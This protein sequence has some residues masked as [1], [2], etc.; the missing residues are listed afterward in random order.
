MAK[1]PTR[2]ARIGICLSPGVWASSATL[3]VDLTRIAGIIARARP[4]V[5]GVEPV[6]LGPRPGPV[7]TAGG[8]VLRAEAAWAH[9]DVDVVVV[10]SVALPFLESAG[11][12]PG[13]AEW[14]ARQHRRGSLLLAITTGSWLLAGTG[15]LDGHI[16]TTHWAALE[17]CRRLSPRVRWTSSQPLAVTGRL[18][19]ARDMSAA[20]TALCHLLG[21][22]VN[23]A[24]AERTYQYALVSASGDDALPL[25][26]TVPLREHGDAQVL[27]AQDWLEQHSSEALTMERLARTVHMSARN[28]RRRFVTA[29]GRSLVEY[30][31]E[32]RLAR[33]RARLLSTTEPVS[34]IAY[35]VGYGDASTFTALFK[36]RHGLT[37]SAFREAAAGSVA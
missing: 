31:T 7:K 5:R 15:V 21:R 6:L 16:A 14:L 27:A 19:T 24:V 36:Q 23:A 13:L 20:S 26:H 2:T 34:Q 1:R 3:A 11:R 30:L 29:T 8:T 17:R 12:A 37:P 22:V 28:L 33:A 35:G 25:L 32:V 10:P 4:G 9:T 18:I